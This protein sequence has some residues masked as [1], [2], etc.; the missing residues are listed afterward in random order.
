MIDLWEGHRSSLEISGSRL[1]NLSAH[2]ALIILKNSLS[3]PKLLFHLR[4]CYS[5]DHQ[6]LPLIEDKLRDLMSQILNVELSGDQ[7]EQATLPVKLGGLGIRKPT[8]IAPSA[9]LASVSGAED[10]V[11][12]I[13]PTGRSR[14]ID[15][16][17]VKALATWKGM[18]GEIPSTGLNANA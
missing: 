7:W 13:L 15:A 12:I 1:V 16:A 17:G 8:Q 2:D 5:G 6:V 18:G 10:L 14:Q 11:K 4:C 3:L 9:Y